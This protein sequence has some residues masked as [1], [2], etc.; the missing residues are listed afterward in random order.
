MMNQEAPPAMAEALQAPQ[1]H[2]PKDERRMPRWLRCISLAYLHR[3]WL[4][5]RGL[6]SRLVMLVLAALLPLV[7]FSISMILLFVHLERR[8]TER[9]MRDT[10]RALALAMDREVAEVRA[11]LGVLALSRPLAAGD[12]ESFYRQCLEVVQ[13]LPHD[14]WLTLSDLQ[15]QMLINTQVPYGIPLPVTAA[16]DVVRHVAATGRPG[17]SDLVVDA[18]THQPVVTLDVPVFHD[19]QGY[20]VLS[21]TRR[22]ETLGWLFSE[23]RLPP[24]WIA[25]V[26]DRQHHILARSREPERFIGTPA[27]PRMAERSATAN[28]GWFPNISKEGTPIYTAFSRVQ[29]TGWTLALVAPAA[30]VDAPGRQALW[31]ISSGGLV[32]SAVAVGLALGLGRRIAAPIKELVPATQ[33]LAQG[34]PVALIP[35]GAVQEVQEVAAA[36]HDAAILL[37]QREASLHEQRARLHI[38]LASIGDAVIATD[39]QGRVT[40]L[41]PVAAALTG[42]AEAEAL[43][44]DS[45]AVFVIVDEHTRQVVDSPITRVMRAG[46]MVELA[47]HTLLIARDGMERPIDDSAAPIRDAEGRLVGV[48]LVF[49]DITARRRAEA[50]RTQREAAQRFLAEASTLL[51]SSLEAT[52]QLGHL[53]QLLVPT[54]GDW[55]SIDLLQ[56]DG[57]IHRVA[58]VHA[59][60]TKA[61]LAE[62]LRQQYPLLAAD[63]SHTLVR[64]LRTGQSWFDP[65][66]SA[67]RLRS[68]ARDAAHWEL[69]QALGFTAEMVLPLL[70]RGWV[71]GTITCVLGEGPRRYSAA[72]LTLAEDLA[73]R[74]ALALDNARLCEEAQATQRA[75]QQAN[76]S[77]EQRV[78][79]RTAALEQAMAERQRLEQAARRAEHFALLGR[80]AAGVSHEIRNPLAAVFLHTDLLTEELVQPSPDSAV[81]IAE[82]L[83]EIKTNL[84]RLD[85]LVQDYLSLVRVHTIQRE[86]QDL[87][88]AVEAWSMEYQTLAAARGM[89][90][91]CEHLADLGPVAFHASTLRRA[92]L[93][94]VQNALDA[95][96]PGGTVTLSGQSTADQVQLQVCDMGS[97]IPAER[98]AQIFEPLHTTK[99]GGTGLGLY[100]VQEIMAAHGGQVTVQSVVGQGTTFTLMLPREAQPLQQRS[101]SC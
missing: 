11:A 97:G 64:V 12:L 76:A 7:L 33:A 52:T 84:A 17:N 101:A 67:E 80:L 99:P 54:L 18:V 73:H 63:A 5:R 49:R 87:G 44:Q 38:T 57:R 59:D 29:S 35:R 22:A 46:T 98:L 88:M 96:D 25:A 30:V 71:L 2:N 41:N 48:V 78:Q 23:Q 26:N 92:V 69:E 86:V 66:V 19:G 74:A 62:Q 10:A 91:Q 43:G 83:A 32:L 15:G 34:L 50:E 4:R 36:L 72:D 81:V 40:F 3:Y 27:T 45:T 94:L 82:A 1:C 93:N 13:L 79:E 58:V 68:E 55:C 75:L 31:L 51:A 53:A 70:A 28:E 24:G 60:P 39:S 61:A 37:Q 90:V 65:A 77:L 42:W 56:D 6:R 47:N 21:L 89:R 14:A 85:D 95:M 16:L 20:A 100:I 9:G 8:T